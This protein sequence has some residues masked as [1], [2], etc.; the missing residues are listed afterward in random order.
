MR[1][2]FKTTSLSNQRTKTK[3]S[4]RSLPLLP[5]LPSPSIP[6]TR[7]RRP[8]FFISDR[9]SGGWTDVW[10]VRT[11]AS[12]LFFSRFFLPSFPS[13]QLLRGRE[14]DLSLLHPRLANLGPSTMRDPKTRKTKRMSG[15]NTRR[16]T[17]EREF[18]ASLSL[19]L[20]ISS[21]LFASLRHHQSRCSLLLSSCCSSSCLSLLQHVKVRR[22]RRRGRRRG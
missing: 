14:R 11:N 13:I 10:S 18:P 16:T 20:V 8:S 22:T 17:A 12:S 3:V 7:S 1:K 9:H 6:S 15:T 19:F 21:F 2:T 4:I 5:S